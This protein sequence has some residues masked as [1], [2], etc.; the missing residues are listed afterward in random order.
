VR[1]I[2]GLAYDVEL[3]R[4]FQQLAK[5]GFRLASL[6]NG[7]WPENRPDRK[8]RR[9]ALSACA[10]VQDGENPSDG[11]FYSRTYAANCSNACFVFYE[12]PH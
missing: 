5:A 6:L 11:S 7:I 10:L 12:I 3:L 2:D 1:L 9:L 4:Q 8:L